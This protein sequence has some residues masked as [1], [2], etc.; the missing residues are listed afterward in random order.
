[1]SPI[2]DS[3]GN[4]LLLLQQGTHINTIKMG[5]R[6]AAASNDVDILKPAQNLSMDRLVIHLPTLS[7]KSLVDVNKATVGPPWLF[8]F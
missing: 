1:M 6:L 5:K 4:R 7:Q 2:S 8:T 3:A